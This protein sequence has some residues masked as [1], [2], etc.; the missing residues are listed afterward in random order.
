MSEP[1]ALGAAHIRAHYVNTVLRELGRGNYDYGLNKSR[2]GP[3]EFDNIVDECDVSLIPVISIR[4]GIIQHTK[5][6]TFVRILVAAHV[7][8]GINRPLPVT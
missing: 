2:Y 5:A 7:C 8:E 3:V 6:L 4:R 1:A